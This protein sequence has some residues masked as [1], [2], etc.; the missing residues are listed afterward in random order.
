[1]LFQKGGELEMNTSISYESF[2]VL[3][4]GTKVTDLICT[5]MSLEFEEQLKIIGCMYGK[6][7]IIVGED[8]FYP[9]MKEAIGKCCFFYDVDKANIKIETPVK[10]DARLVTM[11]YSMQYP[12][13]MKTAGVFHPK[14]I[15]LRYELNGEACYRLQV[16]SR[17]L[18]N[19]NPF[20]VGVQLLGVRREGN[21]VKKHNLDD[22]LLFLADNVTDD[23]KERFVNVLAGELA[24]LD[25]V[26]PAK[27]QNEVVVTVSGITGN[28]QENELVTQWDRENEGGNQCLRI[29][30]P[31]YET[32]KEQIEIFHKIYKPFLEEKGEETKGATEISWIPSHAKL[33]YYPEKKMVWL[34]SCNSSKSAMKGT[35]IECMVRISEV[36]DEILIEKGES[37]VITVFGTKC[38]RMTEGKGLAGN[39]EYD[40]K[41]LLNQ[42]IEGCSIK[43][44]DSRDINGEKRQVN[45]VF[46]FR[47]NAVLA[48]KTMEDKKLSLECLPLGMAEKKGEDKSKWERIMRESVKL[49]FSGGGKSWDLNNGILRIRLSGEEKVETQVVFDD[50]SKQKVTENDPAET[51][52]S[53]VNRA[54]LER[55][56]KVDGLEELEDEYGMFMRTCKNVRGIEGLSEEQKGYVEELK[57]LYESIYGSVYMA[58]RR[59]EY[60]Y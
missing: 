51:Y 38:M 46:Q 35:N 26:L 20:E 5:T 6:K 15:L 10:E 7:T 32:A 18:T 11:L 16:S 50:I 44:E 58:V 17:N 21:A 40:L 28:A 12:I 49:Y 4:E 39:E 36:E 29:L 45:L 37:S 33:Y 59:E 8:A 19:S 30:S 53:F 2:F 3:P 23:K 54:W 1:M 47:E 52:R 43:G 57:M 14:I 24:K 13:K 41:K 48:L 31:D 42:F 55:L 22:F 25:F 60:G 27:L 9:S 56:M 34:G